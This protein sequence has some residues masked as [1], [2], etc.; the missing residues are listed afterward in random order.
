M[1]EQA[2]ILHI[3]KRDRYLS[4][5]IEGPGD[6]LA[7]PV[8]RQYSHPVS[9]GL[10][11]QLQQ[12]AL[13]ELRASANSGFGQSMREL[14][15]LLND[16][17]VPEPI[18]S[19]LAQQDSALYLW[20]E[21]SGIPWECI[22]DGR[23]YWGMHYPMGR[24]IITSAE[25][26]ANEPIRLQGRPSLLITAPNPHQDLQWLEEEIE[27]IVSFVEEFADVTVL[28]GEK[29][30]WLN[31]VRE[32][33]KGSHTIIHFCGHAARD[34]ETDEGMLVL[35]DQSMS[36]ADITS[37]IRG[38]PFVFLNACQ[39]ARGAPDSALTPHWSRLTSN[40]CHAFLLGGAAGVIGSV[41]DVADADGANFAHALYE[42]LIDGQT[43]G[44]AVQMTRKRLFD[45]IPD[46]PVWS[47]YVLYGDPCSRINQPSKTSL[48]PEPND[49]NTSAVLLLD[50]QLPDMPEPEE[51]LHENENTQVR[52]D[53]TA[54][55]FG[56]LDNLE[57]G[58]WRR[59][60][61][62]KKSVVVM[63]ETDRGCCSGFLMDKGR[64]VVSCAE[65]FN[66]VNTVYIRYLDGRRVQADVFRFSDLSKLTLLR[67]QHDWVVDAL[68]LGGLEALQDNEPVLAI[69]FPWRLELEFTQ[70]ASKNY[71]IINDNI[72][73]IQTEAVYRPGFAGAPLLNEQ[74]QLAGVVANE[75]LDDNEKT[76]LAVAPSHLKAMLSKYRIHWNQ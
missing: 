36:I 26:K 54:G 70:G 75:A 19:V 72:R 45:K 61:M 12:H 66:R 49:S 40:L 50:T 68:A 14:G 33:R 59:M 60:V 55:H 53:L 41:S 20:T 18:Q 74:G 28:S 1:I 7:S 71:R 46:R 43:M 27:S 67:L 51:S 15:M 24:R 5:R 38:C 48:D 69:G 31:S 4:Y 42:L 9:E 34:K 58:P 23:N 8:W 37:N 32:L 52:A 62:D 2:T 3:N 35:H 44:E 29:A 17:L 73:L 16:N 64:Y 57:Q 10:L 6:S 65:Y 22:F 56:V 47:S 63:V 76:V 13:R 21:I 30:T 11:K 39:S 25:G